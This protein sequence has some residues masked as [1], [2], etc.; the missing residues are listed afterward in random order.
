MTDDVTNELMYKVLKKIQGD[1]SDVKDDIKDIK[2]GQISIRNQLHAMQGDTL[3][4]ERTIA[5]LQH[6]V[7]R[8]KTRFDLTDA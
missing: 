7:D 3:R 2:E 8:I 1:L 5:S 6:D 4:Q